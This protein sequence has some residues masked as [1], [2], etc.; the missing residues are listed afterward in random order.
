MEENTRT[1]LDGTL[2]R[3]YAPFSLDATPV[4]VPFT[5][6]LAK[7]MGVPSCEEVTLPVTLL[8]ANNELHDSSVSAMI[9][10]F[11]ISSFLG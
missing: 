2:S 10:S 4:I 11:F 3:T 5:T 8:C 7:G 6:M 1:A 9:K